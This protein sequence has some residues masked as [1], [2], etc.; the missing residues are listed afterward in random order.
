M[1]K[2]Q[3]IKSVEYLLREKWNRLCST[4][5]QLDIEVDRFRTKR[6]LDQVHKD[7]FQGQVNE[8]MIENSIRTSSTSI[9]LKMDIY[10][11]QENAPSTQNISK[12]YIDLIEEVVSRK[13]RNRQKLLISNDQNIKNRIS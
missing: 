5:I 13:I 9:C 12:V 2:L 8:Y 4:K 7:Y 3:Y 6:S 1:E 11:H 10:V